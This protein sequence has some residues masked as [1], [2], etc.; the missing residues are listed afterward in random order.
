MTAPEH[1]G[2]LDELDTRILA[3]IRRRWMSTDPLPD[4]L[5]DHIL[6]S[7]DLNSFDV[8]VLRLTESNWLAAARGGAHGHMLNFESRDLG[9]MVMIAVNADGT[10]RLDGWLAPAALHTIELRCA[11]GPMST[12]SDIDGRFALSP[13]PTGS[14]QLV[15]SRRGA[16]RQVVTPTF[17]L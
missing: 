17:V 1:D 15:V 3:E 13:I 4:T 11:H 2:P 12:V 5:I 10:S 6:F 7:V 16:P 8:E 14:A 9:L